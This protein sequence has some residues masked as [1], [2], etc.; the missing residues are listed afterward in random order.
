MDIFDMLLL[1]HF[2]KQKKRRRHQNRIGD[3]VAGAF[4]LFLV[5]IAM[6]YR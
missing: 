1:E 3:F 6:F 2:I 4:V 5:L